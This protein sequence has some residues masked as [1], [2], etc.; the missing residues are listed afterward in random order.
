M[1]NKTTSENTFVYLI[2]SN[3]DFN[4]AEITV[5]K[6]GLGVYQEGASSTLGYKKLYVKENGAAIYGYQT[7]L[8]NVGEI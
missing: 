4:N 2:N 7:N 8:F 3:V 1:G 6:N 5:S